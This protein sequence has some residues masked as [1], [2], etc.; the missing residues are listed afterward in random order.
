MY[1]NLFISIVHQNSF[2]II[3]VD[4]VIE[5]INIINRKNKAKSIATFDFST[6]YTTLPHD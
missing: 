1:L 2:L 4:P 6:L 3:S 5:N